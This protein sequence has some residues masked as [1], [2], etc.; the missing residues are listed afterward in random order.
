MNNHNLFTFGQTVSTVKM[1]K[2][3]VERNE[4]AAAKSA[5]KNCAKKISNQMAKNLTH[6]A[7]SDSVTSPKMPNGD[8]HH[9]DL[10]NV[11]SVLTPKSNVAPKNS[12]AVQTPIPTPVTPKYAKRLPKSK[13]R[14]LIILS[15]FTT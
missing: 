8:R 7:N 10:P 9:A 2:K 3:A 15:I 5:T 14:I 4:S 13:V 1:T 6:N 12:S 11:E